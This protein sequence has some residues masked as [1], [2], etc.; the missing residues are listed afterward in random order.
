MYNN[1]KILVEGI[2]KIGIAV[3]KLLA[4]DNHILLTDTK[5]DDEKL[6]QELENLGINVV[7]TKNQ[8]KL[9]NEKYDYLIKNLEISNGNDIVKKAETLNIPIVNEM[10][11]AYTFLPQKVNVVGITGSN[12]KATIAHLTYEILKLAEMPVKI[13][14]NINTP[15]SSII[16]QI[17]PNDILLLEISSHQFLK[18][19]N[20]NINVL[21][22]LNPVH[23][24]MLKTYENY[25]KNNNYPNREIAILNRNDNQIVS[26]AKD[27]SSEELYITNKNISDFCIKDKKIY[28][29]NEEVC[30][31]NDIRLK[32]KHNYENVMC[33][34]L[35]A[36]HFN[37]SNE[38]IKEALDNFSG[39]EHHLEFVRR[40]NEREFYNDSKSTNNKSTIIAIQSFE[41]PIIL[42]LGGLDRGQNFDELSDYT[43]NIKSII[44]F[45]ETK[46][47]IQD[48]CQKNSIDV[49]ALDSL[50]EAT[51][52]AYNTSEEGDTILL[53]PACA[54]WDQFK[55]FEERGVKFKE[56]VESLQ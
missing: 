32:G 41:T 40:L 39:V 19:S 25:K 37:I 44:C 55:D 43:K 15:L 27:I 48:F 51:R 45:G 5:C 30:S 24:D 42:L 12:G 38:I 4:P 2:D 31:L 22:N 20:T 6:I 10:Q 29:K 8:A 14:D 7:I 26:L 21:T 17:K 28:Y 35:L 47:K 33:S 36:K 9:L 54:S 3:A 23:L 52:L 13:A 53:S 1:K 34:I 18:K 16:K 49:T 46:Q 56:I 50:E 11:V